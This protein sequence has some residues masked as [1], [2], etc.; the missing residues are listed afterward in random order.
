M[1]EQAKKAALRM[2]TYGLYVIGTRQGETLNAAAVNWVTQSSFAPPLLALGIKRDSDAF[3]HMKDNGAFSLS[4]LE[5]G[6][7]DMAFALF[8][9]TE[10]EG[11]TLNGYTYE[12]AETGC[13]IFVDAPAWV[14]GRVTDI[15]ERGDHAVVVAE[16]TNAGV[17]REAK[18]LTLAETGV[19]YGG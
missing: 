9:P 17:R 11:S 3:A 19:Y 4:F 2:I 6:Q 5:S 7:K 1:D 18:P 13:P 8:K 12:T 10:H 14:E 15:V 16:V